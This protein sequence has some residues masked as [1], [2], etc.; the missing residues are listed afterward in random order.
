MLSAET[1]AGKHPVEAVLM[2]RDIIT[3]TEKSLASKKI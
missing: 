1:A 2:M 3:F